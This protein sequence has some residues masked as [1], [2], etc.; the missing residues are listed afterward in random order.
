MLLIEFAAERMKPRGSSRQAN[1]GGVTTHCSN[2]LSG[3]VMPLDRLRTKSPLVDLFPQIKQFAVAFF[4]HGV[5]A[6]TTDTKMEIAFDVLIPFS[7]LLCLLW[8]HFCHGLVVPQVTGVP[9]CGAR[10]ITFWAAG[11]TAAS[12]SFISDGSVVHFIGFLRLSLIEKEAT[13]T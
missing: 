3:L 2:V 4:R 8:F 6:T 9:D 12:A 11:S 13:A 7:C 10:S 5:L 1:S